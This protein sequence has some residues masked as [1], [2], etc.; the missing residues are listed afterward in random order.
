MSNWASVIVTF[1]S[2]D[3]RACPESGDGGRLRCAEIQKRIGLERL[4]GYGHDPKKYPDY[5]HPVHV[6]TI[7]SLGSA[8]QVVMLFNFNHFGNGDWLIAFLKTLTWQYPDE[9]EVF[10]KT[11]DDTLYQRRGIS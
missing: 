7:G 2:T 5:Q 10:F 6:S 3:R 1:P 8:C 11:E 4:T 9:V